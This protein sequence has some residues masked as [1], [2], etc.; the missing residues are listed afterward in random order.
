MLF[1]NRYFILMDK[2]FTEETG[3]WCFVAK[4]GVAIGAAVTSSAFTGAERVI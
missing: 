2:I 1:N 4:P 3:N